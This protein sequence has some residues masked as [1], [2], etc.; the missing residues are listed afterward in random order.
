[1]K[2]H[3]VAIAGLLL[4]TLLLVLMPQTLPVQAAPDA[5]TNCATQTE[6][7]QA[8]CETL[9]ALYNSTGGPN[10]LDSPDNGWNQGQH[11]CSWS[12]VNC[13]GGSPQ[14]V[15]E[16]NRPIDNLVGHLP[17]L[18]ALTSL[19]GLNLDG[20][21]FG[22]GFCGENRLTGSIPNLSTL[23]RLQSLVLS[24]NQLSG[25]IPDLSALTSLQWLELK[26]NHLSGGIPDLSALTSLYYLGLYDNEL[27]GS[28]PPTLPPNLTGLDLSTN[29]LSGKIPQLPA[30]LCDVPS[31]FGAGLFYNM[32][33]G[34]YPP[35]CSY[36]G[37]PYVWASTQTVPPSNVDIQ[38]L[39]ATE[40]QLTWT[41]IPYNSDGGYYEVL[42]GTTPGGPY[43]SQGKTADKT[44]TTFTVSEVAPG[45]P[46]YCVVRTFTPAHDAGGWGFQK[47][48][49][50]S[51][52]S[53]EVYA[54]PQP[55]YVDNGQNLLA[56]D[57]WKWGLSTPG[58]DPS[59][60]A[61]ALGIN[62][63]VRG[64][65]A[66]WYQ[67]IDGSMLRNTTVH[68]EAE[69][70]KNAV[71]NQSTPPFTNPYISLQVRKSDGTWVYNYG[72]IFNSRSAPGGPWMSESRYVALPDDMTTL[73][74][75]FCVWN[76]RPGKAE[77][78]YVLLRQA[79]TPP[80]P[81]PPPGAN[82]LSTNWAWMPVTPGMTGSKAAA[83]LGI[84]TSQ[85]GARGCWIQDLPGAA[86]R[87]MT[88]Q[89]AGAM[90]KTTNMNAP[91]G[92]ANPYL[93]LQVRR[94]NGSWTYNYPSNTI[95]H[96]TAVPGGPFVT[97]THNYKLPTD[98]ITLR[99]SFCVWDAAPGVAAGK[100]LILKQI[101]TAQG[102]EAAT[103]TWDEAGP[104][105]PS[106]LPE[107]AI[108]QPGEANRIW[109]PRLRGQAEDR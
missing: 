37:E 23:T 24:C 35:S 76:A 61:G 16:I 79:V 28:V 30:G 55:P 38:A 25:S 95:L 42:C 3:F 88:V 72:G 12:G 31:W 6:I 65:R 52:Y 46:T 5:T 74:A 2:K 78:R 10:W 77:A 91:Y 43:T 44:V 87:G 71:M 101:V 84:E 50:T 22:T 11:P 89:F 15:I 99:A 14:H 85:A 98:M 73:R 58:V 103:E 54:A 59:V 34:D 107:D 9:V 27:S 92:F 33:S 40:L 21:N 4:V 70:R 17:S 41:A 106:L 109:L 94:A 80:P 96:S 104:E 93:S 47:N 62:V 86:L 83:V 45:D 1:M 53:A 18:S 81:P 75:A 19:V 105:T 13:S 63:N 20:L 82:L 60:T 29:K 7:P 49:L 100:N 32:F 90:S 69:M 8:E 51:S 67:D 64:A 48:D 57:G 102:E 108:A 97:Q 68:F 66:C 56:L 39:S 36:W 26:H